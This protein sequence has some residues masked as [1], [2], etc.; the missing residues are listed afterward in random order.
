MLEK[1]GRLKGT[2]ITSWESGVTHWCLPL[3]LSIKPL[4]LECITP[5]R[6]VKRNKK[7]S[8]IPLLECG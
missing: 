3:R 7:K 4:P 2:N 5:A 1:Y 6:F 8:R